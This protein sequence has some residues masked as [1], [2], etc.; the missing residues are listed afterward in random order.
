MFRGTTARAL[1][2]LLALT[3]LAFQLLT[4]TGPFAPAHTIGQALAKAAP[5]ITSPSPT[6]RVG[7]DTVR[8]EGRPDE[9]LGA[10]RVR[11]RQRGSASGWAQEHPLIAGRTAAADPSDTPGTRWHRTPGSARAHTQAALQVFRR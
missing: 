5:E 3:L 11:D 8:D 6:P 9:P 4:P 7:A 10:P 1:L 2:A